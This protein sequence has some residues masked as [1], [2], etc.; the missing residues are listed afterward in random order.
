MF[1]L[2]LIAKVMDWDDIE[3]TC[4]YSWLRLLA[5]VK[6]DGYSD[7]AA[8][9]GFLEALVDWLHQFEPQSRKTAYEFVKNRLVYI[10]S[11]EMQ[12]VIKAFL[13][14]VVTPYLRS[15]VADESG[16]QAMRS[17]QHQN[18]QMLSAFGCVAAFS[19]A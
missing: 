4:E 13:P 12:R 11:A 10:S 14:E 8:G 16:I 2:N 6:Y 1:A 15:C 3:A 18:T 17:G 5:G 7:F 9:A 19:W